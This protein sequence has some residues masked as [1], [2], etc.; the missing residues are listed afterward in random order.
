MIRNSAQSVKA[1][2]MARSKGFLAFGLWP[3]QKTP[4]NLSQRYL[5]KWQIEFLRQGLEVFFQ[6]DHFT[7]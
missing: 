7:V 5:L 3:T 2:K 6:G 4:I 1:K